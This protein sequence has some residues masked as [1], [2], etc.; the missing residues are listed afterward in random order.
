MATHDLYRAVADPTRRAMLDR[1][2]RG[3]C[4]AGELAPRGTKMTQPA[5]SQHLRVL[6]DARLV[7]QVRRGRQRVYSL[8][9]APLREMDDWLG[10]YRRFWDE[11]LGAL[12]KLLEENP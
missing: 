2:M 4:T 3:D 1:L 11:K 12:G 7:K 5:L 9:L 8:Q 10:K 6:R